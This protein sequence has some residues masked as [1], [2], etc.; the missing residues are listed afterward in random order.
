MG[1]AARAALP[2]VVARLAEAGAR[3]LDVHD[4]LARQRERYEL[5]VRFAEACRRRCRR[6]ASVADLRFAPCRIL[7][8]EKDVQAGKDRLW[9]LETLAEVCRTTGPELLIPLPFRLVDLEDPA[10]EAEAVRWWKERP[11]GMLVKPLAPG[12]SRPAMLCRSREALRLV[13]GPEYTLPDNLERLRARLRE[14][15]S[16]GPVLGSPKFSGGGRA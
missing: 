1:A 5:S 14:E 15:S 7:G 4:L 9:H 12:R 16:T 13:H 3:G 2:K 6:V 11:E 8:T 10:S